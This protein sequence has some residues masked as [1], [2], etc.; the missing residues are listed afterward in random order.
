MVT[1]CPSG[2]PTQNNLNPQYWKMFSSSHII[3]SSQKKTKKAAT[4]QNKTKSPYLFRRIYV[5][6]NDFVLHKCPFL[7]Q[8]SLTCS[9]AC[10]WQDGDMKQ[11]A[12]WTVHF[13]MQWIN[14]EHF[15]KQLS[16]VVAS[17]R[18]HL[19]WKVGQCS[20]RRT[21]SGVSFKSTHRCS[22]GFQISQQT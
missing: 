10:V 19:G 5:S 2:H 4:K 6:W 1:Y 15:G 16:W 13:E 17:Q 22:T 8:R 14:Q 7:S 3:I 11:F 20:L 9:V 18:W 12:A 21:Q